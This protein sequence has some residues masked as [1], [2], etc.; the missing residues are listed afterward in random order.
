M[1]R[2]CCTGDW[3]GLELPHCGLRQYESLCCENSTFIS[4]LLHTTGT[5]VTVVRLRTVGTEE[6]YLT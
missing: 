1:G 6:S 4:I 5:G 3:G 2:K